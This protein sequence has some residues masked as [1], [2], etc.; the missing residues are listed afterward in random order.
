MSVERIKHCSNAFV[1]EEIEK[2][3]NRIED[4][5]SSKTLSADEEAILSDKLM[6]YKREYVYLDELERGEF[7][8]L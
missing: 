1:Y 2:E 7:K 4:I 3:I 8:T 6:E 5:L